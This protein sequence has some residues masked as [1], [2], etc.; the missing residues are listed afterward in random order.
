MDFFGFNRFLARTPGI[1]A[2]RGGPGRWFQALWDNLGGLL[3]GN[4]LS[5]LGFLPLALGVS[6]GLVYENLWMV[7]L[8]G[9]LGGAM[10]G[11]VWTAM[12]SLA[13]QAFRGGTLGWLARWRRA[14]GRAGVPAAGAGAVF[15]LLGGGLLLSGSLSGQLLAQGDGTP[16]LVW[17]MLAVDLFLFSTAAVLLFPALCV[18]EKGKKKD[19]KLLLSLLFAAP[20]RTCAAAGATALWFGLGTA[21]FPVSV[22]FALVLGF[23]PLALLTAQLMLPGLEACCRLPDWVEDRPAGKEAGRNLKQSGEIWWRRYA[24]AA[25][26]LTG[27]AGLL[28]WGG[29]QLFHRQE[30]DL[31]LAVVRAEPLPDSVRSALED[32]LAALVG[33]RN[34]DGISLV[35]VHDYTV[36]FDG[37][38]VHVDMQTAG[39]TQLV[40]DVAAGVSALYLVEDAPGFLARYGDKVNAERCA[41]WEDCPALANLDAGS[42]YALADMDAAV[43]GQSL[44]S[45][46]TVLP[47][48]NAGSELLELLLLPESLD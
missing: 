28:L 36:V 40:S 21:L 41:L 7:L 22:P 38:A 9:A 29:S 13:I 26:I 11:I 42:F 12:L 20:G 5:F 3:G 45:T 48:R 24:P 4:L 16:F 6:L 31:H 35:L 32:S 8:F 10:A 14:A 39:A 17:V 47:G 46:L 33:D 23:W 1:P 44:L 30:P 2:G 15:G 18:R 25:V 34:G 37:S 19:G 27:A 43:S